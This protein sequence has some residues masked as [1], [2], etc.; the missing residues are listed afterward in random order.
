M[1]G[2]LRAAPRRR[3]AGG[4]RG[5]VLARFGA[6]DTLD[7]VPVDEGAAERPGAAGGQLSAHAHAVRRA[8]GKM[9]TL[10]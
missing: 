3:T 9:A 6:L 2:R 4:Y 10:Q 1:T 7:A 8:G 5:S